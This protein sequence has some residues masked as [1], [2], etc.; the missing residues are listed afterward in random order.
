MDSQDSLCERR[1]KIVKPNSPCVLSLEDKTNA[2]EHTVLRPNPKKGFSARQTSVPKSKT[3]LPKYHQLNCGGNEMY[4]PSPVLIV[5]FSV[6]PAASACRRAVWTLWKPKGRGAEHR[7]LECILP[8]AGS[9]QSPQGLIAA[10][11]FFPNVTDGSDGC[12]SAFSITCSHG[13]KEAK[14]KSG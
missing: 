1:K 5:S 11:L 13:F 14:A 7:S 3:A 9:P 12:G 6:C 4:R 10:T 2:A 8:R